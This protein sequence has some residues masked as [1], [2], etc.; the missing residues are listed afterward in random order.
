MEKVKPL[1]PGG[2]KYNRFFFMQYLN[3]RLYTTGGAFE[4]G[5]VGLNQAGTVQVLKKDEW[6]IF[7]DEL[8]KITGYYYH[9]MNCLAVDPQ[10]PE[11]VFVGRTSRLIRIL[12]GKLKRYFNK[13]N[14]LLRPTINKGIELGNDHVP[15]QGLVF[16]RKNNLW[17]TEQRYQNNFIA[18]AFARWNYDRPL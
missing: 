9:D 4:P 13:D 8:D 17:D 10:N 3:D 18:E 1:L 11:H 15:I 2:P 7:Q 5:A 6:T 16:D 14:S 12:N